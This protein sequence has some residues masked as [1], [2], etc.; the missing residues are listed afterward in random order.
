MRQGIDNVWLNF[1]GSGG[2][3]IPDYYFNIFEVVN[4]NKCELK[5]QIRYNFDPMYSK[6][7]SNEIRISFDIPS[8]FLKWITPTQG[9]GTN[10]E[11][12]VAAA[13]LIPLRDNNTLFYSDK[14]KKPSIV[15]VVHS[16][17]TDKKE[18]AE[19]NAQIREV[20]IKLGAVERSEQ[21]DVFIIDTSLLDNEYLNRLL[22]R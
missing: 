3:K 1:A 12:L 20:L 21:K 10:L 4:S 5:G 17:T 13:V 11:N 8:P 18:F 14:N 2:E 19:I 22:K 16:Y 9:G 6:E 15:V 7:D